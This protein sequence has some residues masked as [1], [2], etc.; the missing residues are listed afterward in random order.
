MTFDIENVGADILMALADQSIEI[1]PAPRLFGLFKTSL[2]KS[3]IIEFLESH[4]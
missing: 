1:V 3:V 4:S 2:T